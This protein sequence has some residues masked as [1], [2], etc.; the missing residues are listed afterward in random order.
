MKQTRRLL[1]EILL[2]VT[3]MEIEQICSDEFNKATC[4]QEEKNVP[5][6]KLNKSNNR[7]SNE[8]NYRKKGKLIFHLK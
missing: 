7:L 8:K 1:T 3:N 5:R 4:K 2:E 6:V